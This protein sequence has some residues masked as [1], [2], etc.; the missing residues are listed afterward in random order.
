MAF[1]NI[2]GN[3]QALAML[4]IL[5]N[6][7]DKQMK[8][9]SS[10][11]VDDSPSSGNIANAMLYAVAANS[12]D[13]I[14]SK[15]GKPTKPNKTDKATAA[16]TVFTK[17]TTAK[18]IVDYFK[19]QGSILEPAAGGNAFYDLFENED[20]YRCEIADGL[21]FFE[22][23]KQVDWIITN[24]PY[25]IYDH[26]L[27]KAF[28]V[29]NDVVFFVPIAKAFKS[30]KIQQMVID[31]GGLKEIVY[32]GG[33]SKH[34]FAFGFPVGCLHYQKGFVGDCKIT[35]VMDGW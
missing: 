8:L 24:P 7:D 28:S 17:N 16:D 18:W 19:P 31:Y 6:K 2:A 34:G 14:I 21:D 30:N 33:G 1:L 5:K 29:A 27:K 23:N 9:N 22:W 26:F 35:Y 15:N 25:S 10:T 13:I 12:Q 3:G 32:M 11:T 20:K 4:P